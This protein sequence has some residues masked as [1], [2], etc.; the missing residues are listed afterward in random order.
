MHWCSPSALAGGVGGG[1]FSG[2]WFALAVGSGSDG[3]EQFAFGQARISRFEDCFGDAFDICVH[4]AVPKADDAPASGFEGGG[5]SG[6]IVAVVDV[7]AAVDFD[8]E[9]C[10]AAGD[11]RDVGTDF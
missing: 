4:I 9:P 8:D 7:L 1:F 5:A 11:V 3:F 10:A 6:V 2:S